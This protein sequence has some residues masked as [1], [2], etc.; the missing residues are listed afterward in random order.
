MV[1]RST[2]VPVHELA[3][4]VSIAASETHACV[5]KSDG[6]A[7]CWGPNGA[8]QLGDG[9]TTSRAYPVKVVF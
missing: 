5:A 4:A 1:N 9:T 8:G 6:S 3:G 2:P 7:W